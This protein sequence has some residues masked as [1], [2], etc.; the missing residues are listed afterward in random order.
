MTQPTNP[1]GRRVTG[2]LSRMGED[3]HAFDDEFWRAIPGKQRV[4]MLWNM[5]LDALAVKGQLDGE[6]RLQRSVGSIRR[7]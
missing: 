7:P 6:P 4:E 2:R 1:T 3:E 5:V